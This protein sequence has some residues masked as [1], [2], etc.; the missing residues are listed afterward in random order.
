[1]PPSAALG[2]RLGC[3]VAPPA[4]LQMTYTGQAAHC[5]DALGLCC[6]QQTAS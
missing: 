2:V 3:F 4:K 1:M 6:S 5:V